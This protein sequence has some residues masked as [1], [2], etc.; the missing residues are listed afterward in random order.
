MQGGVDIEVVHQHPFSCFLS[1]G[2]I[3]SLLSAACG[4]MTSFW[5]MRCE[6]KE[7][8]PFPGPAFKGGEEVAM[9]TP[10]VLLSGI[11]IWGTVTFRESNT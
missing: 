6:K 3:P 11:R 4:H 7:S 2:Y 9:F 1:K 5:P 8:R 10:S